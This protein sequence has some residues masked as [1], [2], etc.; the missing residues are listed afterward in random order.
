MAAVGFARK[1]CNLKGANSVEIKKNPKHPIIC[2]LPD[3]FDG[4]NMGAT[5]RLGSWPCKVEK[6]T[7][8]HKIYGKTLIHERHRHRYE[9]NPEYIE[10]LEKNGLKFSGKAPDSPIMLELPKHPF[11]IATQ[12][13]P[14]FKSRV[15]S[16]A[17]LFVHFVKACIKK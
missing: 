10:V 8:A 3:Q 11:F 9:L 15:E 17:P 1:A 6:G 12:G 13:H 7:L 2:I 4:I 16:P 14:E 5:M